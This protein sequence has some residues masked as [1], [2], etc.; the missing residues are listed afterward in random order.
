MWKSILKDIFAS[1]MPAG[2]SMITKGPM[3]ISKLSDAQKVMPELSLKAGEGYITGYSSVMSE[4]VE[5]KENNP[6]Q[7][8]TSD[9]EE[10]ITIKEIKTDS[11][12]AYYLTGGGMTIV[13]TDEQFEKL[14]ADAMISQQTLWEKQV[15][16][17][18][19]DRA[20]AKRGSNDIR[21]NNK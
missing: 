1:D 8:T 6:V 10:T 2:L 17:D 21:G 18:L 9:G 4:I 15:G 5:L 16:I 19:A 11:L 12:L 13:V 20:S 7:L 14:R 3:T